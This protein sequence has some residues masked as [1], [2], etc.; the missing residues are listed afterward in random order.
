M[1]DFLAYEL[2]M[3]YAIPES[4]QIYCPS[5]KRTGVRKKTAN[6]AYRC[7]NNYCTHSWSPRSETIFARS[8]ASREMWEA[9]I[10]LYERN[11]NPTDRDINRVLQSRYS[12][13]QIESSIRRIMAWVY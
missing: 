4:V 9:V 8:R 5:C 12:K 2:T 7:T 3:A 13:K 6:T 10:A 1:N 11:P